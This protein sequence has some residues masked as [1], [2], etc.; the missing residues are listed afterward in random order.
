MKSPQFLSILALVLATVFWGSGFVFTKH[1]LHW[2]GPIHFIAIRFLIASVVIG[3]LL[4]KSIR[5][6]PLGAFV[7]GGVV[8]LFLGAGYL[9]QTIGLKETTNSNAAFITG[10]YVVFIPFFSVMMLKKKEELSLKIVIAVILAAVGLALLS[11]D[12]QL[13]INRGDIWVL[14]CAIVFALHF[15][16]LSYFLRKYDATHLTVIQIWVAAIVASIASG[17]FEP[18]PAMSAIRAAWVSLAFTSLLGTVVAFYI[19]TH[20]QRFLTPT[21][22]GLVALLESPF[23]AFFGWL[24]VGE[25]LGGR[26]WIGCGLML[27]AMVLAALPSK[28][29]VAA[30]KRTYSEPIY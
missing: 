1:V 15:V 28:K 3:V 11:L 22:T 8:G 26:Q 16:I 17:V 13:E 23:G 10:L 20:A 30:T 21:Q 6:A 14:L 4:H 25:V 5:K 18:F 24:W 12:T 2:V 19:Q 29:N 27:L 9:F 7:G